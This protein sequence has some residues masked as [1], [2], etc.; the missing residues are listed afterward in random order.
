MVNRDNRQRLLAAVEELRDALREVERSENS[1]INTE[2][3]VAHAMRG[4]GYV[5][6][7]IGDADGD[8]RITTPLPSLILAD[9]I[10]AGGEQFEMDIL[11]ERDI[12]GGLIESECEHLEEMG[13][14]GRY[15]CSRGTM[16]ELSPAIRSSIEQA[17]P[18]LFR[19]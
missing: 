18:A 7:V 3:E 11:A 14:I 16:W 10:E 2:I 17:G 5:E 1:D 9:L 4:L 6:D 19:E 12:P 8:Q 15:D 13:M